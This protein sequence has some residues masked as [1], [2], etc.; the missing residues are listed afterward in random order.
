M[1]KILKEF[2]KIKLI[3]WMELSIKKLGLKLFNENS[4][5]NIKQF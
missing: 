1:I 4:L 3:K 2:G 5:S